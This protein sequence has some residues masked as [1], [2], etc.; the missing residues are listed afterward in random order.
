MST[1]RRARRRL[2]AWAVAAGLSLGVGLDPC[3]A[4][5]PLAADKAASTSDAARDATA[6]VAQSRTELLHDGES[7]LARGDTAAAGASFERAAS[8]LHA[9]DTEMA[10]V[11]TAMQRSAYREALAFCA[12][13]AGAH[14]DAPDA[15]ALYAWL[16]HA[17]GQ[18][19]YAYRVLDEATLLSPDDAVL[20]AT[21]IAL[22]QPA[23]KATPAMLELP[24][25]MAPRA[26]MRDGQAPPSSSDAIVGSGV[27]I[28]AGRHAI[29][30]LAS[31]TAARAIWVRNGLGATSR[32]EIERRIDALGLALL[33]I[34]AP[35]EAPLD[36]AFD[37]TT[38]EA[39]IAFAASTDMPAR[40]PFPGSPGFAAEFH[41]G[42]G[43]EPAW[44]WLQ[45]GFLGSPEGAGGARR[46]GIALPDGVA[47]GGPVFDVGGHLAGIVVS[48]PDGSDR[49]VPP[50]LLRAA[51][52]ETLLPLATAAAT[53]RM[54][55]D[56]VYERALRLTLQVIAAP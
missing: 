12:H 10:L 21:A 20:R 53:R 8:M 41:S 9:A 54:P 32:A 42:D 5:E 3:L 11:R 36:P 52:G 39:S 26:V 19:D 43:T 48:T 56:E 25:R 40:D 13:T 46:V 14:R 18:R 33:R 38:A 29:V 34:A 50:S 17:G 30:P 23:P 1:G 44:P 51:L 49:W 2:A 15:S 27:V 6:S 16:L 24:H 4:G 28:D 7:G 31:V 35:L 37:A 45:A 22:H 47:R 55:P